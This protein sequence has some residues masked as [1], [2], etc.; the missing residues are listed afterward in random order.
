VALRIVLVDASPSDGWH[1]PSGVFRGATA[2]L[3]AQGHD[4]HLIDDTTIAN[5]PQD[6]A[7]LTGLNRAVSVRPMT[8][9]HRL[10]HELARRPPD[11]MIATLRG[12]IAQAMLMARACGEAFANTRIVLWANQPSRDRLLA[13]D[14][15]I[16]D[17]SPIVM[18]ALERQCLAFADSV[19]LPD[20]MAPPPSLP[21]LDPGAPLLRCTRVAGT[22]APVPSQAGIRE[23]VFMG[24]FKRSAGAGEFIEAIERL[25]RD[26]LLGDRLVTFL[27][28]VAK[29]AYG[30]SK[31]WLGQRATAWKFRFRVIEEADREKALRYA[32][33]AGR[34][35]VSVCAEDNELRSIRA[36]NR[37]H[38]A[39]AAQPMTTARLVDE[40]TASIAAAIKG[41]VAEDDRGAIDWAALLAAITH[42]K[43]QPLR[44]KA[45]SL[46][47]C[48]LHFNRLSFL[49]Q[50]LASIPQ[51]IDGRD[52]E[53]L[54]IDNASDLVDVESA[55][56]EAAGDR[57]I[58]LL[59]LSEPLPQAAAY[60]RGLREASSEIVVFLDDDNI[61][62]GDGL[63]RLARAASAGA[64]DIVVTSLDVFDDGEGDPHALASA[65]RLLFLGTA[66][67][68]GLFFN[69]FGDTAMAVR[70]TSFLALGGFLELG[71]N[72]PSLD[73]VSLAR[74]QGAG[75]RIGALQWPAVRYRRSTARAD[76]QS[77]KLDE[78]GARALV[79]EACGNSIDALLLARHA[80]LLQL[81]DL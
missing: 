47:V 79:F 21:D 75:L 9:S 17:L 10:A 29:S 32:G 42:L 6:S 28:P 19:I 46:T 48:V 30:L 44:P 2:A 62:S 63:A 39:L 1:G 23:I 66:H 43:P 59:A 37:H 60:N 26:G 38:V 50:A 15:I 72:Y 73:W 31:E 51:T 71:Y 61:F 77:I 56:R 54:V 14:G 27:G 7:L 24:A 69:A 16:S 74:A 41:R 49:R 33:E 53:V 4:V 45:E 64:H 67:S 80:Q 57:P 36:C 22:A 34:L 20:A 25:S 68:L 12:G 11:V 81:A 65:G 3:A 35:V 70:R 18:D 76:I 78:A 58:R 5:L 40:L 55:I 52:V 13:S 8:D